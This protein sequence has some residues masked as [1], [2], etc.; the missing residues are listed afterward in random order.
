ME[1][2][3]ISEERLKKDTLINDNVDEMYLYPAIQAAQETGLMPLIGSALYRKICGLVEE[4]E[5]ADVENADYKYLLDNYIIN[6]L[7]FKTMS[8]L[9]IP[10]QYKMRNAGI[11]QNQDER[12]VSASMRDTQYLIEYYD[13]KAKFYA[14]RMSRY[15]CHNSSKYPEYLS[16]SDCSD[17]PANPNFMNNTLFLD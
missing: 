14:N 5:I 8:E 17:M 15:L 2:L 11:V 12:F 16:C 13:N 3:L 6:F 4:G 9:Q 10:L 1:V 7:E